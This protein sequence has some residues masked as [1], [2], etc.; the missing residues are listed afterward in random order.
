[1][2]FK[3]TFAQSSSRM[4]GYLASFILAPIM[5]TRLGLGQFGVWAVT[6]SIATYMYLLDFGVGRSLS[7]FVALHDARGEPDALRA[8][9][10]LG[11]IAVTVV[12][13]L[14][15]GAGALA[16]PL[17]SD[18]LGE[19]PEGEMRVV[20]VSSL[21]LA[22][23]HAYGQVLRAIP[24]GLQRMV[25][26]AVAVTVNTAIN[27]AFSLIALLV[28]TELTT[29]AVA[30]ALA[31]VVGLAPSFIAMR[32][33]WKGSFA[34]VPSRPLVREIASYGLKAQVNWLA[35]LVNLQTD[36]IV[37]AVL[38]DVRVAGAYEI[39][40]RV[41]L[42]VRA[43][44]V[45]VLSA[46]IPTATAYV[47][48]HGRQAVPAFY[49]RYLRLSVGL[50]FP[51]FVAACVTAPFLLVAWLGEVP[52]DATAVLVLLS[53]AFFVN[54]TTGLGMTVS[55]AEGEAGFVARYSALPAAL[56]IALTLV[57]TPLFGLWGVLT[58]TVVGWSIGSLLFVR[59]FGERHGVPF[60]AFLR[61]VLPAAGASLVIALPFAAWF[62]AGGGAPDDRL[63]A[64]IGA[65]LAGGSYS[66]V[67][68]VLATRLDLIP[69]RLTI[70]WLRRSEPVRTPVA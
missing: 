39:G 59:K 47:V 4:V 30:N 57:L 34:A 3:N 40:S 53:V 32:R 8:C 48:K 41:A 56:N 23:C 22:T 16:A 20:L 67:Y 46:M 13:G 7:R 35:D 27:F 54:I 52:G 64:A 51:F 25:P 37:I 14:V 6:G 21:V 28:S 29:Y 18:V 26:P 12:G 49:K 50:S 68:L 42:A 55:L 31:G 5:L 1:M 15:I 38:L 70:P 61:C 36:K 69:R 17:V 43:I 65:V 45:L 66:L 63:G 11:L 44:G 9:V 60:S 62:A 33:V 19:L 58:G 24:T 10:G 2:L